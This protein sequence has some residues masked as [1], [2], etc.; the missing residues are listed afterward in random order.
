MSPTATLFLCGDV[1]TGRGIDQILPH[2]C[3]PTLHEPWVKDARRYVELAEE[4]SGP[5]PDTVDF[6][7]P[8]GDALAELERVG[9]A[10]RIVNLETAV[11]TSDDA[12]A[13]KG[14]HYRMHPDNVSCLEAADLDC[15]CLANNHVLDWGY[16]GL[17]Q[18]L[19]TLERA[20]LPSAGAGR[21]HEEAAAPAAIELK[22]VSEPGGA[23][24][25]GEGEGGG[26]PRE[27]QATVQPVEEAPPRVLV[28]ALGSVT[29]GVL[30]DWGAGAERAGVHLL[31]R[32]HPGGV[33]EHS[34][35]VRR[36]VVEELTR[37]IRRHRRDGDLVMVSI[38][39]GGNWGYGIPAWQ[40]RLAH[41]LIEE[42][43]VDLIHGHSSHHV[44]GIE[45]FRGK[46][47]L[48][49]CGDF[50]TDYEGIRGHEE[51]HGERGLMY[52]PTLDLASGELVELSMIPTRM[53]R[54]Q[55]RRAV[56]REAEW[57]A[58]LLDREGERFGTA[59]RLTEDGRL[60]LRTG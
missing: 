5:I 9:P 36:R 39:W 45:V 40:R 14:I 31:E 30:S 7:Y 46:L 43:G 38:H 59:A 41:A 27:I 37:R 28:F 6:S 53:R 33:P 55:V 13:G 26:E 23:E 2:P 51:Y 32:G 18:T 4:A 24:G 34:G 60:E 11:T 57:L 48:Y 16:R 52:F 20:G 17:D 44:K 1:M 35:P 29:A 50:L 12:W 22:L 21:S 42:A 49:G 54:L 15:C 19:E 47:V 8:W 56:R 3:D 10:A 58:Q 25:S